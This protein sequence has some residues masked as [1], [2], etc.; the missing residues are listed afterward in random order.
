MELKK[1]PVILS[2]E[3]DEHIPILLGYSHNLKNKNLAFYDSSIVY[4]S[5]SHLIFKLEG[6]INNKKIT[7]VYTLSYL[8]GC[9][10]FLRGFL[11]VNDKEYLI[12][13]VNAYCSLQIE[14]YCYDNITLVKIADET[15]EI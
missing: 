13:S 1:R 4:R 9:E 3:K 5:D 12:S 8:N 2:F 11:Y 6:A 15:F 10:Q 7:I 14:E